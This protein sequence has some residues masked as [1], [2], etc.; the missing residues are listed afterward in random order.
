MGKWQ[1]GSRC[2]AVLLLSGLRGH[3]CDVIS[4]GRGWLRWR[5]WDVIVQLGEELCQK[6]LIA[7]LRSGESVSEVIVFGTHLANF[8]GEL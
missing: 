4:G 2:D 6:L 8:R 7:L 1:C 5:Q 3:L